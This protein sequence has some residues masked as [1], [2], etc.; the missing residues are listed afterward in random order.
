LLVRATDEAR[1]PV[2]SE[3]IAIDSMALSCAAEV[4]SRS[5][6]EIRDRYSDGIQVPTKDKGRVLRAFSENV[7][8]AA[9]VGSLFKLNRSGFILWTM[10]RVAPRKCPELFNVF[11]A[12]DP[13]LD[14]FALLFLGGSWDSTK[15]D[16]YSLP[17]DTSL[18]EVYCPLAD[19]KS[20]ATARL[21]DASLQYPERAA[22]RSVVE[23]NC[24]YGV[25]GTVARR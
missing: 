2:I 11:K 6:V 5:Y 17:R 14:Q 25:D 3:L 8:E 15:G 24:L 19:L 20:H 1:I 21:R 18:H 23:G 10:A 22:W 16:S 13:T 4:V 12:S 9:K 7:L